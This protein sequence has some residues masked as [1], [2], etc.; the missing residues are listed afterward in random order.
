[1]RAMYTTFK[2]SHNYGFTVILNISC[3]I[4][5]KKF[6]KKDDNIRYTQQICNR[7]QPITCTGTAH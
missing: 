7:V 6:I 4:C 3:K 5:H 1:M 2:L